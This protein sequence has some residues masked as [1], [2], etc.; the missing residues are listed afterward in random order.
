[1]ESLAASVGRGLR[2]FWLW[3]P[4]S[5]P[6]SPFPKPHSR[7]ECSQMT[8]KEETSSFLMEW[9]FAS[10]CSS[11]E[12][13]RQEQTNWL[14]RTFLIRAR[15]EQKAFVT[16]GQ[17]LVPAKDQGS[18]FFLLG[19]ACKLLCPS[20]PRAMGTSHTHSYSVPRLQIFQMIAILARFHFYC[21]L[22]IKMFTLMGHLCFNKVL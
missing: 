19:F 17:H 20:A 8:T 2:I 22:I 3:K 10:H 21:L 5:S 16:Q 1:M 12:P 18:D 14:T 15:E 6:A 9:F 4:R 13:L 11:S 7:S